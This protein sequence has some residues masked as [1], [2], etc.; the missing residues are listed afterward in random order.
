MNLIIFDIDGTLTQTNAIDSKIFTEVIEKE[1]SIEDLDD[2]WPDYQYSTDNGILAEIFIKYQQRSPTTQELL[3]IENQFVAALEKEF[4]ANA[5]TC[6]P[7]A[8]AENI[9]DHIRSQ[10]NWHVALATG[11]WQRSALLK[12]NCAHII[13]HD[14]PKA[15]TEDGIERHVIIQAAIARAQSHYQVSQYDK[16]VYVSDRLWDKRAAESLGF[17]FIGVGE[18]LVALA[19]GNFPVVVDYS[20]PDYFINK[21]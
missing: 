21:L 19:D 18:E 12:L 4:N 1:L 5:S 10:D 20:D 13:H 7:I 16:H 9:F 6:L 14:V 17:A 15:F 3:R 8:G 11:G 2:N